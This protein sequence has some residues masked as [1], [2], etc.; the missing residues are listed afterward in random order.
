MRALSIAWV[1][2]AG[3]AYAHPNPDTRF[4]PGANHH[5][6]DDSFVKRFGRAPTSG[7]GERLRMAVHLAEVRA[8]LAARPPTRPELAARRAEM[9][10][11]LDD[12]ITRGS[13]PRNTHL[14]WR[15]PVFIDDD[16]RICA[17]GYLIE[18][19][20]GR[21]LPERIA[22]EH[23]YDVLE[24]IAAAIPEVAAWI[25]A[26]GLT[27]DEL[28]S[29][30][31]AYVSPNVDAWRS[32]DL[33]ANPPPDG[34]YVSTDDDDNSHE[35]IGTFTHRAMQG[36]WTVRDRQGV[37]LGTGEL[38]DGAG[39]WHSYYADGK[40][41][42]AEGPFAGNV[43]HGTWRFYH[44]SGV[45]AAEGRF[46]HGVRTGRWRFYNDSREPRLIAAGAFAHNGGVVGTWEHYDADGKLLARTRTE[47]RG[48][49]IDVTPAADGVVRQLHQIDL[50]GPVE[51]YDVSLE[52]VAFGNGPTTTATRR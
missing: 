8:W 51:W 39:V 15:T 29:I 9:L 6:G 16:G 43:A 32:W 24:D 28:A 5:L 31:P 38:A 14:P 46:T 20:V 35:T 44:P 13:T 4:R 48:E 1:C 18:R 10:G 22:A 2:L 40:H 34:H 19:S 25:G 37:V 27:L 21:T 17:V 11:Y 3:T 23:R 7:D 47:G 26:S 41:L 49:L 36:V 33:S 42:L 50:N 45:V 30:Q 52:R 12:Y